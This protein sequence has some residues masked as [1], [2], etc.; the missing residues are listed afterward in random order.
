MNF[1]R[2]NSEEI[3]FINYENLGKHV[4]PFSTMVFGCMAIMSGDLL[5]RVNDIVKSPSSPFIKHKSR[6]HCVVSFFHHKATRSE[7]RTK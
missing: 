3:E 7:N 5:Q 1:I 6:Q 2:F 4:D